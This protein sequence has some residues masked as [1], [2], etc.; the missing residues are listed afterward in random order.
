MHGLRIQVGWMKK[1]VRRRK[2]PGFRHEKRGQKRPLIIVKIL[3]LG[4][5]YRAM[6][7]P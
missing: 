7:T 1:M 6:F 3:Y 2:T 4:A 5:V